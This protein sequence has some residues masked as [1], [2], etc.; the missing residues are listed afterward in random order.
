MHKQRLTALADR[1]NKVPAAKFNIETWAGPCG[2]ALYHAG[3]MPEFVKLGFDG[4][5]LPQY[6]PT[7]STK[8][9]PVGR[10]TG[11]QAAE[12]FFELSSDET[13]HLFSEDAY[14]TKPGPKDVAARIRAFVK[15]GKI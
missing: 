8:R 12:A 14:R 13:A 10:Y 3:R 5:F 15:K 4:E 9:V 7:E 1:L 11:W 2:C 6:L